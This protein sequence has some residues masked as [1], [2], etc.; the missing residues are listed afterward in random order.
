MVTV[1]VIVSRKGSLIVKGSHS[2]DWLWPSSNIAYMSAWRLSPTAHW[3]WWTQATEPCWTQPPASQSKYRWELGTFW[4][5]NLHDVGARVILTGVL[6]P[7]CF[8]LRFRLIQRLWLSQRRF[9][10]TAYE[11]CRLASRQCGIVHTGN[12]QES[13]DPGQN[14]PS[15]DILATSLPDSWQSG[16]VWPSR[17]CPVAPFQSSASMEHQVLS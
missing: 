5:I 17:R 16:V 13:S 12:K 11:V 15:S 14:H 9:L 8:K 4:T 10:S 1:V 7:I 2:P 6:D 3:T